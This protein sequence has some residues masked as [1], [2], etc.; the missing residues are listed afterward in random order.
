MFNLTTYKT[1]MKF[2]FVSESKIEELDEV[3]TEFADD[4]CEAV[5]WHS[6][7][8]ELYAFMKRFSHDEENENPPDGRRG[9]LMQ[10]EHDNTSTLGIEFMD[11]K[12]IS[13]E[14]VVGLADILKKLDSNVKISITVYVG[15]GMEFILI[16]NDTIF[17]RN[18]RPLK[19]LLGEG[20]F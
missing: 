3:F 5:A 16:I 2:K 19:K 9:F 17:A 10:C 11:P 6:L 7:R 14:I 4:S 8:E 12:L 1:N 20:W 18:I 13:K 15:A